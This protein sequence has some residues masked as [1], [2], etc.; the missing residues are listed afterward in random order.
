MRLTLD[1][2]EDQQNRIRRY[3]QQQIDINGTL[4]SQ[5]LA[6]SRETL[7]ADWPIQDIR[8]LKE[9]HLKQIH[10]SI[11]Q[12]QADILLI[13]TGRDH[14]FPPAALLANIASHRREGQAIGLEIMDTA[15]ACR[16]Y[17]LILAEGRRVGALL[18]PIA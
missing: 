10:E 12:M 2:P 1:N 9:S 4:Y 15:A 8:E 18:F 5:T 13:G 16:T 7:L 3:D 17:D 14:I 11:D 6:V